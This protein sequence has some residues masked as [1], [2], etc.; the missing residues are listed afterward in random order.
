M[1]RVPAC[2]PIEWLALGYRDAVLMA[3]R[4]QHALLLV[5]LNNRL[6]GHLAKEPSGALSFRYDDIWL[7]WEQAF[8]VSLSLPLR[9]DPSRRY[10]VPAVIVNLLT[11]CEPLPLRVAEH[12]GPREEEPA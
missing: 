1:P 7:G 3:R 10:P 5:Y 11:D 2:R 8:P 12:H 4:R 6:V 9:E